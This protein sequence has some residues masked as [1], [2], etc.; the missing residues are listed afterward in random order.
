ME[1]KEFIK[2]SIIDICIAISESKNELESQI[3]NHPI[4]PVSMNGIK[5]FESSGYAIENI[6]FDIAVT[7]YSEK[8]ASGKAQG[9][10]KVISANIS[11]DTKITDET[12]S[13]IKFSVPYVPQACNN[14]KK[15]E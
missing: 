12:I 4:A 15:I 5:T 13:R 2:T 3:H 14:H 7:S 8:S 1:L 6:D 9:G 10:I 11:G